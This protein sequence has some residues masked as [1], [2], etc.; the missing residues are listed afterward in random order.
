MLGMYGGMWREY[1]PGCFLT[2][3]K[4][5]DELKQ[6]LPKVDIDVF[7]IDNHLETEELIK[8]NRFN[9]L[10][11]IFFSRKRQIEFLENELSK[12]D[13]IVIGGDI[14]WGGDD[15][16]EDNDIF[17]LNSEKF[18]NANQP[19]VLINSVHSFYED[20]NIGTV[21]G[22]LLKACE[23][24]QYLSVRTRALKERLERIGINK[25]LH[26]VPDP[27]LDFDTNKFKNVSLP[28]NLKSS[29]RKNIGISVRSK[30]TEELIQFLHKTDL[31]E[32]DVIF[33]PFSRQYDNLATVHTIQKI[34][35]NKYHYV[36]EYSDPIKSFGITK[37]FDLSI[38]DT[39]HGVTS[40]V[41]QKIPFISIDVEHEL[42]SRKDQ[43]LETLNINKKRNVRL[44]Y[45]NPNN[46]N[47][48]IDEINKLLNEKMEDYE[49]ALNTARQL[50]KKHFDEMAKII[51]S[52]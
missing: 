42:T 20:K 7:S 52:L 18:I 46:A 51:D 27:V 34:F 48:L 49:V 17:F 24:S 50:I 4:T 5:F 41:I 10:D 32:Y 19:A 9:I 35:G 23:R 6:R 37:N 8:E 26:Q 30:L 12:Y 44:S 15:V 2:G 43:L 14:V 38:T 1:N 29:G 40:A 28:D 21:R 36:E 13:A 45:G 11:I 47:I 25:Q 31:S 39:M 3:L 33:Y 22:K 16:I